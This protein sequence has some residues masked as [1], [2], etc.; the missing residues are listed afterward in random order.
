MNRT[1]VIIFKLVLAVL[2]SLWIPVPQVF[3]QGSITHQKGDFFFR[4]GGR[5]SLLLGRNPTGSV[6][7]EFKTLLTWAGQSGERI[8]RIH[9]T[10]GRTATA[11]PGEVDENWAL[12]WD[13][14][15]DIAAQ[16]G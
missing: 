3:A 16:N 1:I 15:F 9:L 7:D 11:K 14:V 13:N 12:Y 2:L 6:L 4:V 10:I 8:V 5:P